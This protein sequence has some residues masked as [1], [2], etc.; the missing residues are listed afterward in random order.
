MLFLRI[1][2]NAL[3]RSQNHPFIFFPLGFL[4]L[5][6]SVPL[7]TGSAIVSQRSSDRSAVGRM[8]PKVLPSAHRLLHMRPYPAHEDQPMVSVHTK[9][10]P[11]TSVRKYIFSC[12][13]ILFAKA[14]ITRG[15]MLDTLMHTI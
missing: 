4:T 11:G 9:S 15:T 1:L 14:A 13:L 5:F 3:K 8:G 10:K 7:L 6:S 12:Y 2:L